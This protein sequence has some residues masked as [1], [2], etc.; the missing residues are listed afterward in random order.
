VSR[1]ELATLATVPGHEQALSLCPPPWDWSR[2]ERVL[3]VRLRSIGDAVLAT[4]AIHALRRWLP[5]AR[6]DLLLEDWVAPL[7]DGPREASAVIS[8]R[9]GSLSARL[10]AARALR[11][12]RYDVAFDLHGGPTST[13]LTFASGARRRVGYARYQLGWLLSHR[14]P[15]PQ[16]LWAREELHSVEQ[17]LGLLGFVGVPVSDCPP[18]RLAPAREADEAVAVRLAAAGVSPRER[19]A[20][21]HPAAALESKRWSTEGFARVAERLHER[22]FAPVAIATRH[23]AGL[24]S[25]LRQMTRVPL[26]TFSDL[27]LAQV[28]ALAARSQV[29]V[30]NDSGIAHVAVAAGAP[31]LVVFG[32]SSYAHWR[33]WTRA[34][35]ES[36]RPS[37]P[38]IPCAGQICDEAKPFGCIRGVTSEQ[39]LEGL[40]RL[41][42]QVGPRPAASAELGTLHENRKE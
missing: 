42:A 21:V 5:H 6:I 18:T 30:G 25:A 17:Q 16:A 8:V 36:V 40:E 29:F 4:P 39:V 35:A 10:A 1:A 2:V 13:L 26:T 14:A 11:R 12:T 33:P 23:E 37:L 28:V 24:L 7:F 9:R 31:V 41:L 3:V 19:L 20:L 15:S 38:C 32:S 27:P 22:G 34:A